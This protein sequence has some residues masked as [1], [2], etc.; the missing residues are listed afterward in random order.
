[1]SPSRDLLAPRQ[2]LAVETPHNVRNP[3]RAS[4]QRCR[5]GVV[6]RHRGAA[7]HDVPFAAVPGVLSVA[8]RT[9]DAGTGNEAGRPGAPAGRSRP[10]GVAELPPDAFAAQGE[11]PSAHVYPCLE[12]NLERREGARTFPTWVS[13][14]FS[15][16]A[17]QQSQV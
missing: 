16:V 7:C 9:E 17:P 14:L 2:D 6:H 4:Y 3:L 12:F 10:R 8:G 11:A 5:V 1:M 13:L 15:V